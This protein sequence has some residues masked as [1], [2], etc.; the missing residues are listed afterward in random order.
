[1]GSMTMSGLLTGII[2]LTFAALGG[3]AQPLQGCPGDWAEYEGACYQLFQGL[4]GVEEYRLV[5]QEEGGDLVS[6]HSQEENDFVVA[7]LAGL[8]GLTGSLTSLETAS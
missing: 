5:C 3:L 4:G 2:L 1:M 6:I 8:M 7:L